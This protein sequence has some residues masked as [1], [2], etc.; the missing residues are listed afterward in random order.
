MKF[1]L[2]L[3]VAVYLICQTLLFATGAS[4]QLGGQKPVCT[5]KNS[6]PNCTP[7]PHLVL[8]PPPTY[9]EQARKAKI[10]GTC[11]LTLVVDEKGNPTNLR[12]I[13]GLGM[14]LDEKAIDNVKNWKFE[15]ALK[16]GKPV[17]A[18]IAVEVDFH[19]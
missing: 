16:D 1:F 3:A 7:I 13:K 2:R 14:G 4:A 9:S 18:K 10:E 8:S 17:P 12:V 15:P 11:I 6:A 19:L 5:S